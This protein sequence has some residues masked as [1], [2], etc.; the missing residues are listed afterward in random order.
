MELEEIKNQINIENN[1]IKVIIE[2]LLELEEG[3]PRTS[4]F[5]RMA[6]KNCET[7]EKLCEEIPEN[8]V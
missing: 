2:T 3:T 5:L 6:L 4:T 8:K 7:I 1:N